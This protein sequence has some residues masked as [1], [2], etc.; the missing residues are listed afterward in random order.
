M[1][2]ALVCFL[3]LVLLGSACSKT[4]GTESKEAVQAA[5]ERYLQKQ[6]S[7]AYNNMTLEM[8]TSNSRAT[9]QRPK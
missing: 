6:P 1:R 8:Q 5:I 7:I 4:G 2:G 3:S 9:A